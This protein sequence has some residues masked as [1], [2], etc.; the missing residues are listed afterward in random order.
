MLKGSLKEKSKLM[1]S[2][3]MEI[4]EK[5]L[6][7]IFHAKKQIGQRIISVDSIE[8][9][10]SAKKEKTGIADNASG[11]NAVPHPNC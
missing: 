8:M 2:I 3:D 9:V 5:I 11:L 1:K 4:N 10:I 6:V 7:N